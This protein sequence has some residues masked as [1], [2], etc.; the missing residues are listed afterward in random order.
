MH[1]EVKYYNGGDNNKRGITILQGGKQC[2]YRESDNIRGGGVGGVTILQEDD[3]IIRVSDLSQA[4]S[5]Y[6]LVTCIVS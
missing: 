6:I 3:N 1:G 2:Y 5:F 4:V